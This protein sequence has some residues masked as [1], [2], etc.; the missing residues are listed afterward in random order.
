VSGTGAYWHQIRFALAELRARNGQFVFERLCR[1][2]ARATITRNVLP[3]TGPVGAGGD[4]GRDFETFP[5]SIPDQAGGLGAALGVRDGDSIVF[6]CTLQ[7]RNIGAKILGDLARSVSEGPPARWFVAYCEVDIPVAARHRI[8]RDA[9]A[10]HD[11]V[12]MVVFDGNAIAEQLAAR[13][14]ELGAVIAEC[15]HVG[16]ER[17]AEAVPRNLPR[18]PLRFVNREPELTALDLMADRAKVASAPK[19]AVL[20]G[21][22]GVGKSAVGAAWANRNRDRFDDGDLFGDFSR[23]RRGSVVDVSEVLADLIRDLGTADVAI[24]AGFGA[25]QR[26]FQKLTTHRK[27]L[28]LLD[29]VDQSAQVLPVIPAGAGSMVVV[30]T[31][32]D[33]EELFWEGAELIQLDPLEPP[34]AKQLL[35]QMAGSDRAGAEPDSINELI[36]LCGG[37]PIV[38]CVCGGTL[39][40]HPTR[41]VAWLVDRI[42]SAPNRLAALSGTG[43]FALEAVLDLAYRDLPDSVARQYRRLG[44]HPGPDIVVEAAAALGNLAVTHAADL[45]ETLCSTH[46]IET[47]AIGR[48]RLHDLVRLHALGCA[49][50]DDTDEDR[51]G[52]IRRL[53]DWYYAAARSADRS[54]VYDRLRLTDGL[55]VLANDVPVFVGARAAF[56][57]FATER[58]NVLA[59]VRAAFEREWDDRVWQFSEALWP[60]CAS[61]KRFGEWIESHQMAVSSSVR[62]GD[63]AAEARVR[64]QLAR[65]YAEIG[66]ADQT[67]NQMTAAREAAAVCANA[68]LRASVIEFGGVCDLRL[69]RPAAALEAFREARERFAACGSARAIALQ[70]L[71]A[72]TALLRLGE[73]REAL[74]ALDV[75]LGGLEA[76]GDEIS[77]ARVLVRRGEALRWVGRPEEAELALVG[78]VEIM[79][80]LGILFEQAEAY[81]ELAALAEGLWDGD[82]ARR[83]RRRAY[84]LYRELSHPRADDLLAVL[85]DPR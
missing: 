77:V 28:L 76:V 49:Q 9:R 51:C 2:L 82:T 7:Q 52:S 74:A 43:A 59:A 44:L 61:H 27:L 13:G 55:E 35:E 67:D 31:N 81:E 29:D 34:A 17:Q 69:D 1:E 38:L 65:A 50:R 30:T 37:L 45:L 85:G 58:G 6:S 56:D 80:R 71:Y 64:S 14:Q 18:A 8:E 53:V 20:A 4:Q 19:V 26:L 72:G 60:L 68:M 63:R 66:D 41:S 15:L 16:P 23:R 22:H 48:F 46:L 83:H 36:A 3:A 25:R 5:T 73:H 70:D 75:A 62:L 40:L 78:A 21:M 10:R 79:E 12:R 54:V 84:H 42:R 11:D 47:P 24:P 32:Y 33:L 39:A 57:W